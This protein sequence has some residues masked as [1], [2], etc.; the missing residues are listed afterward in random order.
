MRIL[1]I[2]VSSGKVTTVQ[3][4][5]ELEDSGVEPLSSSFRDLHQGK[6][7]M[8]TEGTDKKRRVPKENMLATITTTAG[9]V[10]SGKTL[11]M[12]KP[13]LRKSTANKIAGDTFCKIN[14]LHHILKEKFPQDHKMWHVDKLFPYS[15]Y[16]ELLIDEPILPYRIYE[17]EKKAKLFKEHGIK[18][19]ALKGG[20][21][22]IECTDEEIAFEEFG[23]PIIKEDKTA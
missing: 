7:N 14:I 9:T 12:A 5:N 18:Y 3:S 21:M 22:P 16:G 6:V 11:K 13:E 17:C 20:N 23:G 2:H 1:L 10:S 8:N 15:K 19:I 4:R